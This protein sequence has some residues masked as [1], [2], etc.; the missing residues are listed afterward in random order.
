METGQSASE[1]R[2]SAGLVSDRLPTPH[3]S[4]S[5]WGCQQVSASRCVSWGWP[6]VP[7]EP[8]RVSVYG[9][10]ISFDVRLRGQLSRVKGIRLTNWCAEAPFSWFGICGAWGRLIFVVNV[11]GV[12][13]DKVRSGKCTWACAGSCRPR[14]APGNVSLAGSLRRAVH[15]IAPRRRGSTDFGQFLHDPLNAFPLM[16]G[17]NRGRR[18]RCSPRRAYLPRVC[19]SGF[20]AMP[21]RIHV[22]IDRDGCYV[23]LENL[24]ARLSQGPGYA[25][26]DCEAF[27]RRVS[28]LG[29]W[30]SPLVDDAGDL[31]SDA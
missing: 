13:Y 29:A 15:Q 5:A 25:E 2:L 7:T 3:F 30:A 12:D 16:R 8:R 21:S 6:H 17:W 22:C 9:I 24:A 20:S 1:P 28:G 26:C 23:V 14:R 18:T 10:G 27:R 4:G 31:S 19:R 11:G